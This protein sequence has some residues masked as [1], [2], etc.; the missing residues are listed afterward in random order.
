MK[1]FA[2][3]YDLVSDYLERRGQYRDEHLRL[4]WA[5]A[6]RGELVLGGAL[7][8][9]DTAILVFRGETPEVA[10]AFARADPYVIH[11]LVRSHRVREWSTV[12]GEL[13]ANPVRPA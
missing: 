7:S 12:V 9:A 1:H 5:A 2:L 6:D 11:G 8:P 4:A 13:A 3:F 10:E